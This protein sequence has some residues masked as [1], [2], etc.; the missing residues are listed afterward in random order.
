MIWTSHSKKS[1]E[2]K[3]EKNY[4]F[5]SCLP[6]DKH[7]KDPLTFSCGYLHFPLGKNS[8]ILLDPLLGRLSQYEYM[9]RTRGT[10]NFQSR[11]LDFYVR[12]IA[13]WILPF[14]LAISTGKQWYHSPGCLRN[15]WA[16]WAFSEPPS[17]LLPIAAAE[18]LSSCPQIV[19]FFH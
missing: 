9:K 2:V 19:R 10:F 16:P 6:S 4:W 14:T 5:S 3:K 8:W 7:N 15:G 12:A 1:C 18:A 17:P 13:F 11:I